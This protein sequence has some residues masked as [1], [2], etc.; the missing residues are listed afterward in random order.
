MIYGMGMLELGRTFS[1]TQ[2]VIDNEIAGMVKR[3][4]QGI[5]VSDETL[6]TDLIKKVGA[7]RD[8]LSQRHTLNMMKREQS[9][10][11]LFDEALELT[12]LALT[13]L[14][15]TAKGGIAISISSSL[16]VPLQ[17]IGIGEQIEDLRKFDPEQYVRALFE[18]A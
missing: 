3:V 5:G 9:Q 12:G 17:Y 14:D 2:L 1:F 15:G 4:I 18:V 8:F 7:G 13:K 6:A 10:A 16:N 11:K